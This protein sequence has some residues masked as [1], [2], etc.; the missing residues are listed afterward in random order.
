MYFINRFIIYIITALVLLYSANIKWGGRHWKDTILS[1]GKGYYVYLPAILI[2]NDLS[3][4]FVDEIEKK[5]YDSNTKYD[6]RSYINGKTFSKYSIG[7]AL[8]MLPF[9]AIAHVLSIMLGYATDGYSQLYNISVCWAAIFY[10][11]VGLTYLK[12]L[13][14]VYKI[15][16]TIKSITLVAI[17]FGTN[18]FYYV[19][20]EPAMSH[21]Y[22]FATI[23]M[24]V[25]YSKLYFKTGMSK[26]FFRIVLLLSC[27][28]LIKQVN[29][30][31]V[32]SL[33]FLAGEWA[34]LK[35]TF[36]EFIKKP[37]RI[38]GILILP[39]LFILTQWVIYRVQI[40]EWLFDSYL[41]EAFNFLNPQILSILFSYKKGLFVYTPLIFISL[42]GLVYVFKINYYE[43]FSFLL[44]FIILTYVLS[45]WWCWYYGGSFGLRAYIEYYALFAL[46][47]ALL[48][49]NVKKKIYKTT[50]VV[51]V[52]LI[53]V[54]CQIQTWQY[55]YLQIHWSDMNKEKYWDV[56][57]R[58]DRILKK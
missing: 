27:I 39:F 18:L 58:V 17:V 44:F 21:V 43:F 12:K 3:F 4:S 42:F 37:I 45:S 1:D 52:I 34:V 15:Q 32:L 24:F 16:D 23:T 55:R 41:G 29:S 2:Y 46:L 11:A 7:V 47:L 8:L 50:L 6:F 14:A 30:L 26:Y 13:L 28:I 35:N 25:Y 19:V 51:G 38:A 31:I 53:T 9:F 57:M 40:G 10:M 22:S 56:F 54:V 20:A 36:I 49:E 33:P 48:L 5:Y